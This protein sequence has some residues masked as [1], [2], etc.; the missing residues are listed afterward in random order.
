[1]PGPYGDILHW[2]PEEYA[3]AQFHDQS[4]AQARAQAM[5]ETDPE[6][7]R[8]NRAVVTRLAADPFLHN[9]QLPIWLHRIDVPTMVFWGE[10]D[11]ICPPL[12]AQLFMREIAGAE[13]RMIP[14]LGH[15]VH[16][17]RPDVTAEAIAEFIKSYR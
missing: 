13:L 1:V 16:S 4:L 17:E 11:R 6:I 2:T 9:P 15:S 14:A 7:T 10:S 3:S 12:C 5:R 8:A